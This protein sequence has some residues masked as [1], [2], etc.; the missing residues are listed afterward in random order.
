[1]EIITAATSAFIFL[2]AVALFINGAKVDFKYNIFNIVSGEVHI[3]SPGLIDKIQK[4]NS[5][6]T[7]D[8]IKL[9]EAQQAFIESKENLQIK[10]K[11]NKK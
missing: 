1:M 10:K 6:S 9:Q 8:Q 5:A 11:K 7:T 4:L 3:K 2:S